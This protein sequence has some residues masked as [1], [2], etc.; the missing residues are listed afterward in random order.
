M[1]PPSKHL[2]FE[3]LADLADDRMAS[4]ARE[5]AF[6]HVATCKSCGD[7]YESLHHLLGLMKTDK[8]ESAPR[9]VIS[10]AINIF[11][12]RAKAEGSLLRRIVA[13]LTFDSLSVAPAFG[14]RSGQSSTRQFVFTAEENDIDLRI[15]NQDD[16]WIVAGQVLRVD[17]VGGEVVLEGSAGST[18]IALNDLCEFSLPAVPPGIYSLRISL[19][20]LE[21]QI[22]KLQLE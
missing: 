7:T 13:T 3:T 11:G 18:S 5:T 8:S 12:G 10:S 21:V 15:K 1:N 6:S 19:A 14:V 16:K 4:D 17:C 2:L 22:P 20:D 9:D